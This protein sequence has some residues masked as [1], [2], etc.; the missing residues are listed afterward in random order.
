MTLVVVTGPPASGKTTLARVIAR[1][2]GWP[3]LA[4]DDITETLFD[5]LGTGDREWSMRLGEA[6]MRLL[7]QLIR[8]Q[9]A[10]GRSIVAEANFRRLS[11]LPPCRVVQVVCEGDPD[12]LLERYRERADHPD[13]HPG[14]ID[15]ER[16]ADVGAAIR[17]GAHDALPLGGA[18]IRYRIGDDVLDEVKRCVQ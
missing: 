2:L 12:E 8:E 5:A 1:E 10:S 15:R 9:L 13:R 18:V 14:H 17:S 3:L 7:A 16:I 4:K 11:D 6:T